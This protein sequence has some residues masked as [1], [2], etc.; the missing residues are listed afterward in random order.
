[1]ILNPPLMSAT[2]LRRYKR[3]LADLELADGSRLTVHCPNTGAM[4]GCAEP[5]SEAWYSDSGND[6]RKYR[7]TLEVVSSALGRVG[8]NTGRANALIAEA[9]EAGVLGALSGYDVIR[10]EV[11]SPDG[12]G[13]FDLFLA[14]GPAEDAFVEVK[15]MTLADSDGAGYFPDAVSTRA[16]KHV[17]SLVDAKV[18]GFRAALVFCVQHT[19]VH[20]ARPAWHIHP[21]YAEALV[22]AQANGVEIYAAACEIER[23]R[24]EISGSLPVCLQPE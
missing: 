4:T 10:R 11:K 2:L 24:I 20:E 13:R 12:A 5:G 19:G 1:M 14:D 7:H 3:F 6:K 17:A 21:E 8:V 15:S 22:A 16:L 18:R 23:H 9:I